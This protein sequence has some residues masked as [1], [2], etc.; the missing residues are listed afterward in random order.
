ML[1]PFEIESRFQDLTLVFS[2]PS[3]PRQR[4]E[5]IREFFA[6]LGG[7]AQ[8]AEPYLL[9]VAQRLPDILRH[10]QSEGLPPDTL[11]SVLQSL[12]EFLTHLPVLVSMKEIYEALELLRRSLARQLVFVGEV[13]R[14]AGLFSDKP[15]TMSL[16]ADPALTPFELLECVAA[17]AREQKHPAAAPFAESLRAWKEGLGQI[18]GK[19][20]FPAVEK[21]LGS[22]GRRP[23]GRLRGVSVR[24]FAD[25]TS[26]SDD[27]CADV[28]IFQEGETGFFFPA[29]AAA[30]SIIAES[31]PHLADRYF[32]GRIQFDDLSALHEGASANLAIAA[33]AYCESLRFSNQRTFYQVSSQAAFTGG[34]R[35]D[36]GV[37]SVEPTS[38]AAKIEAVF[39]SALEFLA[40]PRSQLEEAEASVRSLQ[41]VFPRRSLSIIGVGNVRDV[42]YDRRLSTL[43]VVGAARHLG[44]TAWRKKPL[45][46][47]L[48][49]VSILLVVIARLLLGP[50]DVRP[51]Y[52]DASGTEMVVRNR[53]GAAIETITIRKT[54]ADQMQNTPGTMSL[55]AFSDVNGDGREEI[56]WA[57]TSSDR[58]A[59][60][61]VVQCKEVKADTLLWRY[62]VR[63]R[64]SFPKK[65]DAESGGYGITDIV[66][67]DVDHDGVPDLFLAAQK[68]MFCS[69]IVRLDARTGREVSCYLNMGHVV[70]LTLSDLTKTGKPYL[71]ASGVNNAFLRACLIVLDPASMG[72]HSP[73]TGEYQVDSIRPAMEVYY[74][75]APR[76]SLAALYGETPDNFG[77][78]VELEKETGNILW[79]VRD[80]YRKDGSNGF[81]RFLM[82]SN[83]R[84]LQSGSNTEFD[85]YWRKALAEHLLPETGEAEYLRELGGQILYWDGASWQ[86]QAT[87]NRLYR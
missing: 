50:V 31:H 60:T 27:I 33:V 74:L 16:P 70:D 61:A 26:G 37:L 59:T 87:R 78:Y 2:F 17:H 30:R 34:V 5:A 35:E 12:Q 79:G 80:F 25:S 29:L 36:G 83:L 77:Q 47:A 10:L 86:K 11:Q 44:R 81:V 40:V 22:A 71:V 54:T 7:Q 55:T 21:P 52:A 63:K 32:S 58:Y 62:E 28:A 69:I 13:E 41:R 8:T 3:S 49:V 56:V 68:A 42:F 76:S 46:A 4:L 38:L 66:V 65:R 84:F 82:D 20:I 64:F 51:V 67:Q 43:H 45:V 53:W 85:G 75:L 23:T 18:P 72:G 9:D 19:S 73:W 48:I 24:L 1:T 14:A 6:G 57:E 39:F 15:L